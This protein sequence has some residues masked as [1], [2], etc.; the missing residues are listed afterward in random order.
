MTTVVA[1]IERRSSNAPSFSVQRRSSAIMVRVQSMFGS[2]CSSSHTTIYLVKAG[3]TSSLH[4]PLSCQGR[5]FLP[6]D[7]SS[8]RSEGLRA[9]FRRP[10]CVLEREGGE[11]ERRDAS[12]HRQGAHQR[13]TGQQQQPYRR[14]WPLATSSTTHN[15]HAMCSRDKELIQ[16]RTMGLLSL[17]SRLTTAPFVSCFQ[18]RLEN[19][20]LEERLL[21]MGFD[22]FFRYSYAHISLGQTLKDKDKGERMGAVNGQII[23]P[24]RRLMDGRGFIKTVC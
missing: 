12:Y 5:P 8:M 4:T 6:R 16:R 15:T 1:T 7:S 21:P 14:Q 11:R 18:H 24:S 22:G 17:L 23:D 10:E 9:A 20:K 3:L 2:C 19:R 13:V